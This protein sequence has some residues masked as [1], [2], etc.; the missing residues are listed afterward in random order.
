MAA[1][2]NTPENKNFMTPFNW[3][4]YI[5]RSPHLNFFA[6]EIPLP[7][8]TLPRVNVPTPHLVLPKPGDHLTFDSVR[9]TFKVDEDLQNYLEIFRWMIALGKPYS[10]DQYAEISSK[11]IYSGAGVYSDITL[12]ILNSNRRLNYEVVFEDA[13][14]TKLGGVTFN[15]TS[16]D[17]T[18]LQA[19]VD[20]EYKLYTINSV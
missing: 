11:G 8:L 18:F 7:D 10:Y 2:E 16:E 20:F 15:T 3:K 14:P 6:Q 19:T 12:M 13:W 17:A 1:I 5:K 4:F 9:I